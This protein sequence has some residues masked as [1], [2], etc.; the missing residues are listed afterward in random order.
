MRIAIIGAMKIEIEKILENMVDIK[1][2]YIYSDEVFLGKIN[3]YDIVLAESKV[4]ISASS[5]QLTAL[6]LKYDID[7]IINLGV[8][9]GLKGKVNLLDVVVA[10]KI[11]YYDCD[12]THFDKYVYGQQPQNPPYFI[13]DTSLL[14]SHNYLHKDVIT[15]DRFV[16]SMDQIET[17]IGLLKDIDATCVDMESASFAQ[18]ALKYQKP[19][20]VV[21]TISD[22][23]GA[24]DQKGVYDNALQEASYKSCDF[25]LA[26]LKS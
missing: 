7:Y 5:S 15:G 8:C 19:L 20:M 22:I 3:N 16:I 4:G 6:I 9:G 17:Q 24:S 2:D 21:R 11:A 18:T 13:G 26:I 1:K 12:A 23:I 10:K 14:K 25:V